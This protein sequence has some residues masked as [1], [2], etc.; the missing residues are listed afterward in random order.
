MRAFAL[1]ALV[2]LAACGG[3]ETAVTA[4]AEASADTALLNAEALRIGGFTLA[5]AAEEPWRD[6]WKLPAHVSHDPNDAQPLGSLVEGR[7]LEVRAYPG[8]RVRE[9]DVLVVVHSHEMMD[10]RQRLVAARGQSVSADSNLAVAA[11][12]VARECLEETGLEVS[13]GAARRVVDR[14]YIDPKV[15]D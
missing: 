14:I 13:V 9:G 10:A 5:A 3:A 2:S 8:D 11:Q 12:A 4:E 7:V 15:R 1:L 6:A